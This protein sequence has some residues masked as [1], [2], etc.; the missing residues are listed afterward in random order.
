MNAQATDLQ[1]MR[2]QMDAPRHAPEAMCEPAL[3]IGVLGP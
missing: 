2:T 1:A 3:Q